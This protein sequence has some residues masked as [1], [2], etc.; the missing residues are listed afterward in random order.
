[1]PHLFCPNYISNIA[2]KSVIVNL[3]DGITSNNSLLLLGVLGRS[4]G[5]GGWY[6]LELRQ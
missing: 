1:M 3:K 2:G 4:L 6:Q 5:I